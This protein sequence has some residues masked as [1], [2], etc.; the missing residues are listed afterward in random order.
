LRFGSVTMTADALTANEVDRNIE[1]S[2][3]ALAGGLAGFLRPGISI[4]A[5]RGVPLF[6]AD[7]ENAARLIRTLDGVVERGAI[8]NGEFKLTE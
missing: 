6:H 3:E 4:H 1:R 2:R 8:E 7:P 5:R